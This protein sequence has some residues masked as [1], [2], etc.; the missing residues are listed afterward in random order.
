MPRTQLGTDDATPFV[1]RPVPELLLRWL[2]ILFI[3]G[4]YIV[5]VGP[6]KG[7]AALA[8]GKEWSRDDADAAFTDQMLG[9]A[10]GW[11]LNP[12]L[13]ANFLLIFNLPW[14]TDDFKFSTPFDDA[15][16]SNLQIAAGL[17]YAFCVAS[18]GLVVLRCVFPQPKEDSSK[19]KG[20]SQTDAGYDDGGG[21]E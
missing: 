12:L 16:T 20:S 8:S 19:D 13:E 7:L 21:G 2:L 5:F 1:D 10:L 14:G 3:V 11:S 17:L 6:I 4:L 15:P 18:I 9:M